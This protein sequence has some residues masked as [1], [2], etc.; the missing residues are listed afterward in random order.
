T[1]VSPRD[2]LQNEK[3]QVG[4]ARK[5]ELVRRLTAAGL[6][7]IEATA[8][9]NPKLVPQMAD[10]SEV[11][12]AC[13][14]EGVGVAYPV[15]V[16]NLKGLEAA[17]ACG[18]KEVTILVAASDTFAQKNTNC[19]VDE[20]LQ[21]A[22]A[23]LK[24][25][26][27]MGIAARAAISV[28]LGCP[29]E[30]DVRPE[31]VAE[32][33]LKLYEA[34]CREVVLCDTIG[35]GTPAST[36]RLLE[37]VQGAGL[38][39]QHVAVHFHDT[40]GQAVAN[41]LVALQHGVAMADAAVGGI[42][43]CP[44]A[45]PG[46]SGNAATEDLL[47]MLDGM[48]I[49]TG[50]DMQK[51]AETGDWLCRDVLGREESISKAGQAVLRQSRALLGK[52]AAAAPAATTSSSSSSHSSTA[53][54]T[55][56]SRAQSDSDDTGSSRLLLPLTGIRVV[57]V[58]PGLIAGGWTGAT[59]AYF[60]A[61]VVKVEPPEGDAIRKWRHLESPGGNSLWWQ[62]IAR[63]KRSVAL[64][65]R[66]AEGRA[67]LR[68]LVGKADILVENFKPGT[69]EKWGLAPEELRRQNPG[70]VVARV[71]GYGQTG[72]KS[73]E[74]GFASVCEGVG[75]FRY[76]NGVPGEAPVRPNLS[77][78]DS[79]AAMNATIGIL[80]ALVRRGRLSSA[81][82]PCGLGQ[83]VDVS[84]VESVFG[85]LES[86][87]PEYDFLGEVRQPSGSSLT[88]I[89]PTGTYPCKDGGYTIIGANGDS[90]FKR[91]MQAMGRS[92]LADDQRF[93]DNAGRCSHQALLDAAITE[94]TSA[95]SAA[96]V[97]ATCRAAAVPC[98]PI[99]SVKDIMEDEHFKARNCF[100]TVQLRDGRPLKVPAIGPKLSLTPGCTR[101]GG[102]TL[103]EHTTEVLREL[104]KM[105]DPEM[106]ALR[107]SGVIS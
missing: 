97:E 40:Y 20:N 66:Q 13:L 76:V 31:R 19:T 65:L 30:G 86:C 52:P 2:G 37:A 29:Y 55:S 49:E 25:A 54:T 82:G 103:G 85:M 12:R 61:D 92:D 47:Q 5:L 32:V 34:G 100:E 62:S 59:L 70:L 21:R 88:G 23:I 67:L 99:F 102:P 1:D 17:K 105:S 91:L 72:P 63:N 87:V 28:C 39:M 7:S 106:D 27:E 14:Q 71:S 35:T 15:L 4:T 79:L 33:A 98:G 81:G 78:G 80:L 38:P 42:G 41:T 45:G 43:G 58:G 26:A 8:F 69:L 53:R 44:F 104:L 60:G 107:A 51:L 96:E 36:R 93:A 101:R 16:P 11:L 56:A 74:P 50:V 84:I 89:V 48:G 94:W 68:G 73:S 77:V 90:L 83:D 57:E 75:G 10:A 9:V 22:T 46:A 6:R 95:H 24:A 3:T 18:A 64:D